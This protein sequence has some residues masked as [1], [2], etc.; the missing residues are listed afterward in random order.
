MS[1]AL[2]AGSIAAALLAPAVARA[3]DAPAA[4]AAAAAPAVKKVKP[5]PPPPPSPPDPS[6]VEAADDA[7]LESTA[8]RRGLI[9]TLGIGGAL[10]IGLGMENATGTGGAGTLRVAH[11]ANARAVF[12]A[13]IVG[14]A[15]FFKIKA[16]EDRLYRTDVQNF[17]LSGQYYVNPA[18]WLR[19]GLGLGRYH[20]DEVRMETIVVRERLRL[21][22][23][24]GSVGAGVDLIRLKRFRAS[25]EICS[26]AMINR[27]G[28]L[29][30]NGFL[31]GFS[32]D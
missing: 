2:V 19:A 9:V 13:E 26:T 18:L 6:A 25:L 10:S 3:G 12:A 14:S 4:A 23:P 8:L 27:E 24:A 15:L 32:I 16:L 5:L 21:I 30:S 1:R 7:N 22:G 31:F 11:V 20:G 17:L 29:S 28:I